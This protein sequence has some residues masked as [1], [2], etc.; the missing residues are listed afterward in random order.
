[1]LIGRVEQLPETTAL[2]ITTAVAGQMLSE[3]AVELN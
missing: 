3:F 2:L 1:M